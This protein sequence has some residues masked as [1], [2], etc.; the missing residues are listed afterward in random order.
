MAAPSAR[1]AFLGSRLARRLFVL[2]VAAALLPLALSDWVSMSAVSQIA[3]SLSLRDR[4]QT[5][6]QTG[7]QVF[8]R[9]MAGK[10]LLA[11]AACLPPGNET[12][13]GPTPP[14]AP[15]RVFLAL[16]C[17]PAHG[18]AA[19]MTGAAADLARAWAA[20]D[21]GPGS[22]KGL[23][24]G[25]G[26]EPL[27]TNLRTVTA[28]GG[29]PRLLLGA[30]QHGV[31]HRVAELD[32][33]YLW[34]PLADTRED[35][36][37][38]VLD[39]QGRSLA[40]HE[41]SDFAAGVDDTGVVES[42]SPLFLGAEFGSSDWFFVQRS[43]RAQVRWQ[44]GPLTVWLGLVAAGTL[45]TVAL[46]SQWQIR[47]TLVPLEQLTAGTQRLAAGAREVRVPVGRDDEI[48]TLA[49]AFNAMATHID[50][51]LD[52]L[53]GLAA[54]DQ[55]ILSGAPLARVAERVLQQLAALYPAAQATVSWLN[56]D[57]SLSQVRLQAGASA[58]PRLAQAHFALSRGQIDA[59]Q[60][61]AQDQPCPVEAA[62]A[63]DATP[64]LHTA[65]APGAAQ[66]MLLP[67]Q[68]LGRTQA[69][70]TLASPTALTPEAML[71]AR[72]LRDRLAVAWA[73]R[74][75][76]QD[77][78]YRAAHDSLTGLTNRYGLHAQLDALL[79][80]ATQAPLAVVVIDLDHFKDVNDT[81]GHEAGDRLL[82]L[83]SERLM[84]C[85]PPGALVAR[86]GGDEFALVLPGADEATARAVARD[87]IHRM[88][89]PFALG[90]DQHVLGASAGMALSP[91]HGRTREELLRCADIALY[92][93]KA[94]G[95]GQHA[96]FT[97]AHDNAARERV[98]LQAE[99][100]GALERSEFVVHYQPRVRPADG[101][102]TSAEALIRW[103]RP[104]RELLFPGA[105]IGLAE[106]SGLIDGI[107]QW[108]LDATCAQIAA[109]REQ[110]VH[111]ERVSVNVSPHQLN[112]GALPAQ[113]RAALDRHALPARALELEVTE[114]LMLGDVGKAFEQLALMRS[115]G[116]SIALDDFGTGYSSMATLH[117]LPIDVMK[118]DRS[119]V[120]RLGTDSGAAAVVRAIVAL[121]R[122]LGLHLVAEGVETETQA[123]LLTAQGCDE[124]QGYLYSRPVPAEQFVH[125]PGLRRHVYA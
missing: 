11:A 53:E 118:I 50:D 54:I 103:Q 85:V 47:R 101:V 51:Q 79:Q 39:S 37:W 67:L 76:E 102:V 45:L 8:D 7:R 86:Q 121:A 16:A 3:D 109:W 60:R 94:A 122:A 91:A 95:R 59:Y 104:G 22:P 72:E 48:G 74:A 92:A 82:C 112:S 57:S 9:L 123:S 105:F 4:D 90:D 32:P 83:A 49:E 113:V 1:P 96:V 6:R 66:L 41:G 111:L 10:T 38:S 71:P 5:T 81:R 36:A 14:A 100:R 21:P 61:L 15:G 63:P 65:T 119:F 107:G 88:S 114:S 20:A 23:V 98:Q 99:L 80:T 17:A 56:D 116:V 27:E 42:R 12:A 69:L 28:A 89:Q 77:L 64:W 110:G 35:S 19:S 52:A 13:P 24:S 2:F 30:H 31:L 87:A 33:A 25:A 70:V 68:V 62:S 40:R 34:A 46:L 84:A 120:M 55:D 108:I 44:G 26:G 58:A 78:I 73:A 115:W 29:P 43:P 75:R 117:Q 97:T 18:E 125:L 93:A 106:S 124:L